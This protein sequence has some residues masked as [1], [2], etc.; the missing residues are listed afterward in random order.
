MTDALPSSADL[1][2][3]NASIIDG[4]GAP[5]FNGA[6]AVTLDKISGVFD[7]KQPDFN[8]V[9]DQLSHYSKVVYDAQGQI[10]SPGFIDA[11]THDDRLLLSHPQMTPKVSQGV[12]TVVAGNC[13]ISLAPMGKKLQ[14]SVTPPLNLLDE[15]GEWFRFQNFASYVQALREHPPSINCALLLGHTTLRVAHVH[16]LSFPAT[17]SEVSLMQER[18]VEALEAGAIGLSTGLFYEPAF[19]ASSQ[20]VIEVARPLAKYKGLYC[21]HMRDEGD[22]IL[23]GLDESFLIAKEVNVPLI[24]SHLKV[25]GMNN[26]GKSSTALSHIKARQK[27]QE[28]CF[29]C[30]PYPASSTILSMDRA[31]TAS[32]VIVTWSKTMPQMAGQDL[33]QI[34]AKLRL[35][36]Q[37]TIDQLHPAGAIYFRM[38]EGDVQNILS[39]P[40]VMIGSDGLPHDEFPHP[41]LWGT[42][43]KV[44]GHY[45]R[46]LGLFPLESAIRKMTSSTAKN[47]R[48]EG[49]GELRV[50]HFAD[51]TL[52]DPVIVN[53]QSSY[54]S[55]LVPSCGILAVWVNGVM[56]FEGGVATHKPAGRV[57][58]H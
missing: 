17:P 48:L 24:I 46:D 50:G 58:T 51:L 54:E 57:L 19:G 39:H 13:G 23:E 36:I 47:F 33:S 4:T 49:R 21:T 1:L 5:R 38:D 45:S 32:R 53:A 34:A 55:P 15:S 26:Y 22:G 8:L 27:H 31:V 30:Y 52:F 44:L 12:T 11:H 35:S 28:I 6:L 37:E 18:V 16:D 43:T 2:I 9:V 40:D 56:V 41:R 7:E 29:D 20:E 14:E 25:V 3:L 10:L 42:F